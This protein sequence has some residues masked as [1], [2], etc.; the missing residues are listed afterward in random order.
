MFKDLLFVLWFFTPSAL[1]NVAPI[2]AAKSP[3]FEKFCYPIDFYQKYKGKRIFGDHK[4]IRGFIAG[5]IVGILTV[6]LQIT[7]YRNIPFIQSI[8]PLKYTTVNP[9][10]LGLL[11]SLGA[12]SGDAIKSFF[13]R[14]IGIPSGKTWFPFDQI[15]YTLGAM[16]FTAFYIHLTFQQYW[17]AFIVWFLIHPIATVTGWILGLKDTPI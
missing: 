17:I 6:Y 11:Q 5:I 9:I 8:S 15:D 7:L 4:T 10:S 12:L 2:L 13:K 3:L 14:Q 1:A 16:I